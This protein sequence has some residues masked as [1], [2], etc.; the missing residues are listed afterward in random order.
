MPE[1]VYKPLGKGHIR[2]VKLLPGSKNDRIRIHI[3]RASFGGHSYPVYEALSYTWS[4]ENNP[5]EIEVVSG[6][7]FLR[8]KRRREGV[9][10]FQVWANLHSALIHL[11]RQDTERVLWIDA[12]CLN[13]SD[14]L[15]KSLELGKMG[16]IYAKAKNVLIWLGPGSAKAA[17]AFRAMSR[18]GR[19][20]Q[21]VPGKRELIPVEDRHEDWEKWETEAFVVPFNQETWLAI[22]EVL[23]SSWFRRVWIWQEICLANQNSAIVQGG[24]NFMGWKIFVNAIAFF[25]TKPDSGAVGHRESFRALLKPVANLAL[26]PPAR[27]LLGL[28]QVTR[29]SG[30]TDPH[31]RIYG[32]STHNHKRP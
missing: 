28:L 12:I 27:H 7:I 10:Y 22:G 30:C 14:H 21:W 15:E 20:V 5:H 4:G 9:D 25:E 29:R 19:Q 23:S 13:Q 16:S 1:Y 17:T 6:G 2:L 24:A 32:V 11:R 3:S 8:F 18:L 26:I 31:D